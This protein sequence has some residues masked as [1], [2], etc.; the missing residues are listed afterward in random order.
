MYTYDHSWYYCGLLK[1][2]FLL[3]NPLNKLL[4]WKLLVTYIYYPHVISKEML[5]VTTSGQSR[6]E[7]S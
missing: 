4:Q 6:L 7:F 3:I 2:R 5:L 1:I